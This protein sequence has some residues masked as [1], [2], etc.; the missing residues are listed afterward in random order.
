MPSTPD[1][2]LVLVDFDDTLVDTA[3]RFERARR[4]LFDRM[5][6]LGY[7]RDRA[8]QVHHHEV[9]PRL[10]EEFGLGPQRMPRAFQDTYRTLCRE[11]GDDPDPTILEEVRRVGAGVA[12]TPPVIDGAMAALRRLAETLPTLV[13]TQAS[14][15]RYQLGCLRDAGA[16]AAVGEDR[17][18][19]V[20][21]KTA[22][23]LR[24]TL[25]EH[26]VR[27]PS[28]AW[29]VG[30]SVRSDINPALEVGARALL[31]EV[32][33]PWQHDVVDPLHDGFRRVRTF[34]DAVDLLL[35]GASA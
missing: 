35:N 9:D 3:P 32:D 13:Y 19:V 27:D 26:G 2:D 30:N 21:L 23:V 16:V 31:V 24:E 25:D 4:M 5:A 34:R 22:G 20:P 14:D 12:G 17:V 28:R 8:E 7:D 11:S 29:M 33:E 18:R 10:R 1:I 6:A 15:E